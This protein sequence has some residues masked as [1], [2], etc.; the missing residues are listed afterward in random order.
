M[1]R[2]GINGARNGNRN[3]YIVCSSLEYRKGLS[4]LLGIVFRFLKMIYECYVQ[5]AYLMNR[6]VPVFIYLGRQL[7]IRYQPMMHV[8]QYELIQ[9][10]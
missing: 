3:T 4:I 9:K 2:A 6:T 10:Q 1:K 5:G 8:I 7:A